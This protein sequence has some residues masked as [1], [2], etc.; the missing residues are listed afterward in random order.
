MG[1][2]NKYYMHLQLSRLAERVE[3]IVFEVTYDKS[4]DRCTFLTGPL[5]SLSAVCDPSHDQGSWY[6]A[7]NKQYQVRH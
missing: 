5:V 3:I 1:V 4:L 6:L 2:D 7:L